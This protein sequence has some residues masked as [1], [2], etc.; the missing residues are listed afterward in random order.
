[1]NPLLPLSDNCTGLQL[2]VYI[3]SILT[4]KENNKF[5]RQAI[6]LDIKTFS[7]SIK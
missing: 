3:L 5:D 4:L 7:C 2:Q 6:R 1:M